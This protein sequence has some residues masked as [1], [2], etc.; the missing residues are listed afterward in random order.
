MAIKKRST[1]QNDSYT[2]YPHLVSSYN[3]SNENNPSHKVNLPTNFNLK[4]I[5]LEDCDRCVWEEFNSRFKVNEHFMPLI[6]LDAELT[7]I[8]EQNVLQ[9]DFDK[10]FLNGPYFTMFRRDS[11]PKYRTNPAYKQVMYVEPITGA[12]G[13]VV[14][15][16]YISQGPLNYDL[17][18]ELKFVTNYRDYSNVFEQQFRLYFQN[19]RN[20]IICNNERFSIGPV[21]YNNFSSMEIVNRESLESRTMYVT[22]Y[23]LK[24]E[25]FIRNMELDSMQTRLRPNKVM[26]DIVVKDGNNNAVIDN[27]NYNMTFPDKNTPKK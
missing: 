24:L 1:N 5:T 14:Y 15:K 4:S 6:V 16:E 23:N 19:K 3:N 27:S 21:D 12:D 17:I 11:I 13:N 9:Y 18:Y 8:K 22:T 2:D 10:N 25:C 26:F 7:S 20:I